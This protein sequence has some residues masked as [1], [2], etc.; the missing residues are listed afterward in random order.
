LPADPA[1]AEQYRVSGIAR[2]LLEAEKL[3]A[4]KLDAGIAAAEAYCQCREELLEARQALIPIRGKARSES[5]PVR[6]TDSIEVRCGRGHDEGVA[7][8][9][10]I[11]RLQESTRGSW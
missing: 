2:R 11:A 8:R 6:P 1:E 10:L 7:A 9:Q 3:Y 5:I 4:A